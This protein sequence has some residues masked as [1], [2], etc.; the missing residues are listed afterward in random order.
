MRTFL[1]DADFEWIE[2]RSTAAD[3]SVILARKSAVD[4]KG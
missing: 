1:N 2:H 4:G 3:R